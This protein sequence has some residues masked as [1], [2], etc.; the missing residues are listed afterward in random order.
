VFDENNTDVDASVDGQTYGSTITPSPVSESESGY[1]FKYWVV[2]GVVRDDLPVNHTF[3]V[4]S[5]L[6]LI[7]VYSPD[8]ANVVLFI[9]SNGN[10]I[11]TQFV[12]DST[13]VT[14][15]TDLPSKPGLQIATTPWLEKTSNS[16]S[17]TINDDS[18]FVLQYERI[19]TDTFNLNVVNDLEDTGTY[20]FNQLVTL[21]ASANDG[22]RLKQRLGIFIYNVK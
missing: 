20:D 10:I 17:L 8:N 9:D 15:P 5:S 22:N 16:S 3:Y 19:S 2:N 1:T 18:V 12:A 6:N 13:T 14:A 21:T 11:D 7:G 4:T